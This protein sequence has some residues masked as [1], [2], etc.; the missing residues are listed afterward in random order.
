MRLEDEITITCYPLP[1]VSVPFPFLPQCSVPSSE[2][3][4]SMYGLHICWALCLGCSCCS[5]LCI[6]YAK[7]E[8]GGEREREE[9]RKKN[10]KG[11]RRRGWFLDKRGMRHLFLLARRS[12]WIGG[13]FALGLWECSTSAIINGFPSHTYFIL[14]LHII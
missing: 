2:R 3:A 14:S 7:K 13:H 10:A 4:N 12:H 8:C 5:V 1:F 6:C 11:A 9:Q